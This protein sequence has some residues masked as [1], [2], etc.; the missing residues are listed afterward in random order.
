MEM[1]ITK[2]M[3]FVNNCGEWDKEKQTLQLLTV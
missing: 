3:K 2:I 1:E